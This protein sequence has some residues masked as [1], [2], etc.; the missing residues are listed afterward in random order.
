VKNGQPKDN[1]DIQHGRSG[2]GSTAALGEGND[3]GTGQPASEAALLPLAGRYVALPPT[4]NDAG[5]GSH[6]VT[7]DVGY[8]P[9]GIA[10]DGANMWVVNAGDGTV[11]KR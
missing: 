1:H 11:S 2:S 10:F 7:L 8:G 6:V 3:A 4:G 9:I 5:D